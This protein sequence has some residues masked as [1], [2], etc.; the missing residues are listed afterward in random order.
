[1]N[2]MD[3]SG[4]PDCRPEFIKAFNAA[5]NTGMKNY[6]T[7]H[8]PLINLNKAK[9]IDL[10]RNCVHFED[11]HSCYDPVYNGVSY[12]HC[13]E[14]D[15]CIIRKNGFIKASVPDPTNYMSL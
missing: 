1:M 14:C 10:G 9:I 2:A 12:L 8:A 3:Y 5:L 7:V 15:S 4:Y 6:V 13:G 11:T